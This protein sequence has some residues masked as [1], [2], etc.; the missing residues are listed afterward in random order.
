MNLPSQ[1]TALITGVQGQDGFY[2]AQYLIALGYQVVGTSRFGSRAQSLPKSDIDIIQLDLKNTSKV[3]NVIS[4][5]RPNEIYNLA[6]R[7]SS[8]QLFDDPL[9][10]AEING[11]AAVRFL[12]AIRAVSPQIRF[13]QAASSEIF[14]GCAT[15][16]QD[17]NTSYRPLNAYGAAKSYAANMVLSYR[18]RYGLF[19]STAILFNHESP[20]RGEEYVTRKISRAVAKIR[21][22]Q[23]KELIVGSLNS[24]RDW[25]FAGDYARAMWLMLQQT[26]AEDFVIATGK[27]HSVREFCEIAF[28]HVGLDYRDFVRIDPR[29]SRRTD[30]V[31]LCG[32]STKARQH[33]NWEPSVDFA[34][35]VRMMVDA[36]LAQLNPNMK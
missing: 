34:D 29:W 8:S 27:M 28:S 11:L 2:L 33:L 35:L 3:K 13:C 9:E 30:E 21:L 12:E 26:S 1:K 18:V 17:E 15:S 6:A 32:D 36:D 10:T 5:V 20:R 24:R 31:E 16:P 4:S 22:G 14:A 25:G 23:A 19:A 7:S